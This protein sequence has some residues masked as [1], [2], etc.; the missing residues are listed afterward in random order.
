M[1]TR[2]CAGHETQTLHARRVVRT[3]RDF[4]SGLRRESEGEQRHGRDESAWNDEVEDVEERATTDVQRER[5][6]DVTLRTTVVT[7]LVPLR[8][9]PYVHTRYACAR[10][11]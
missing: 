3:E 9:H 4:L 10:F 8:R 2:L 11:S 1:I 7:Y 5:Y 6:V